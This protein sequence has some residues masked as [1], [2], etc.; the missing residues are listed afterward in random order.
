M[1]ACSVAEDSQKKVSPDTRYY[2]G[3]APECSRVAQSIQMVQTDRRTAF[4]GMALLL[5]VIS[6]VVTVKIRKAKKKKR[7]RAG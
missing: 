4:A 7:S 3:T 2:L 1:D 6:L 5:E